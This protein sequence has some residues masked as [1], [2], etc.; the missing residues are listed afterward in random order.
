MP[1]PVPTAPRGT[2]G[3]RGIVNAATAADLAAKK[4]LPDAVLGSWRTAR[5]SSWARAT[6][7][8]TR[9]STSWRRPAAADRLR[10]VRI[11]QMLPLRDRRIFHGEVPGLRHCVTWFL[12]GAVRSAF[13]AGT[14]D[15]VPNNFSEVPHLSCARPPRA[16][17][18]SRRPR[19][20]TST[21]SFS[22]GTNGDYSAALAGDVPLFLEVNPRM[23]RSRGGNQVHVRD[24]VGWSEADYP[25]SRRSRPRRHVRGRADR[26]ARPE[27]IPDEATLQIG[28]GSVPSRSAQTLRWHRR[29]GVHTELFGDALADLIERGPSRARPRAMHR[30]KAI[31]TTVLARA[32]STTSS[33]TIRAS[34]C[35]PSIHERSA[36]DRRQH[37]MHVVNA[38]LE[39]DFLG[40]CASESLGTQYWS[41]S[42][43]QPD[44][45][46]GALF[47]EG[48]Q[49][50]IV[51]ALREPR[52]ERLADRQQAASR[53]RRDDVQERRRQ[54][55]DG[56]TASPS[57]GGSRIPRAG[58]RLI[59]IAHP[60]SRTSSSARRAVR[61][62]RV[63]RRSDGV[64]PEEEQARGEIRS[65]RGRARRDTIAVSAPTASPREV[66][67]AVQHDRDPCRGGQRPRLL[68]RHEEELG[69]YRSPR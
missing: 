18:S 65:P 26:G 56:S 14:C 7:S 3:S 40:Q 69:A 29:L 28:I 55:R 38:T 19:L 6:A 37:R 34:S 23:P 58:P 32:G 48:G 57:S 62:P 45:A 60:P 12:S 53:C 8:R 68:D 59:A 16:R 9:S 63:S 31:A 13:Q 4:A 61:I 33:T 20:P 36:G 66:E 25:P 15:L 21:A 10:D 1:S 51:L 43:G 47:S 2:R 64:D 44:F 42:G 35:G 54:G 46:R 49:S 11:H 24:I 67:L 52:R 17:S 50:F 22:L 39:V 30:F 27:R 41:S 5:M